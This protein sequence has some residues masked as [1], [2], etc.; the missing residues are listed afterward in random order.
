M[1]LS[2]LKVRV[3]KANLNYVRTNP[4]GLGQDG[5]VWHICKHRVLYAD[6][7]CSRTVYHSNYLHYFELGRTS[8]MRAAAYPYREIE[9]SGYIYPIIEVGL[10]IY[11]PLHYDDLMRIYTR[12]SERERV[13]LRF[14]YIIT[15]ETTNTIVCEGFTRHCATNSAGIPVAVDEK[16]VK[17]WQNF[18]K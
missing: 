17:L 13:K 9:A 14:D 16:T 18:P 1:N 8:L 10:N 11:T 5:L 7:D 6:T 3:L 12:P 4:N 2:P 15:Q